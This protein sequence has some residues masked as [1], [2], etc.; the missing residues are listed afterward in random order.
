MS[1]NHVFVLNDW[2]FETDRHGNLYCSGVLPNN[3]V[4]ETTQIIRLYTLED[5]YEVTTRNH[6]YH[7]YW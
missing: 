3:R 6:T 5:R 2:K 7:L 1:S 4:W